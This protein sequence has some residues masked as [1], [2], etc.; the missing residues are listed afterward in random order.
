MGGDNAPAAVVQGALDA[1]KE[2][3]ID[4]T[5]VG[6]E[7]VIRELLAAG[8]TNADGEHIRL[9]NA[10]EVIEMSDEPGMAVRHKPDSSMAVGLR[11]LAR[12]EGDA[13]VSAGSTGAL[14]SGA[15]MTVR[16]VKGIRRA[17]LSPVV[18]AAGRGVLL[19]DCG[20]NVE[21]TA[22]YL[23]QFAFMGSFYARQIMGIEN[24]RVAQ[25]NIG[26]EDT[27]GTASQ[28]EAL[29][30]LRAAGEAGR[31]NFIGN[32]EARE[33]VLGGTDVLVSDGFT[34]NI[35]LKTLE[36]TALYLFSELKGVF[37]AGLRTKVG[38]LLVRDGLRRI[39]SKADVG[40]VGGTIM[41]G[42]RKTVVKAHGS[43][44]ARAFRSAIRQA[45]GFVEAA[46][47]GEI[48]RNVEF[49]KVSKEA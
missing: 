31:I 4:L 2:F 26:V 23:L 15:T 42:L 47:I 46:V 28:I 36:G 16:R 22:E 10:T 33:A 20:A 38:G 1:A 32:I 24:P 35:F 49:M 25:L 34:G 45:I 5:L 44:D 7:N 19:I 41:L 37:S 6:Q 43:S 11:L 27:K 17:A 39:K 18:P 40:E 30:L 12:G 8:G 9:Q 48:E 3:N 13:F 29:S 14:L 21:C